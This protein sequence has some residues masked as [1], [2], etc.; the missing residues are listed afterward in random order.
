M[1]QACN[2]RQ[3]QMLLVHALLALTCLVN[4]SVMIEDLL[5]LVWVTAIGQLAKM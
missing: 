2:H 4:V 1:H 3:R 5:Q